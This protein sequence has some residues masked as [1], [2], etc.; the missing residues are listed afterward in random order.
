[1]PGY[2]LLNFSL[3]SLKIFIMEILISEA[4]RVAAP[5]LHIIHIEALIKNGPSPEELV[6]AI[7]AEGEDI[8]GRYEISQINKRTAIAATRKAYKALGK[9]PNRYRPSAEALARRMVQGKG[10][11]TLNRAVDTINLIS[12]HTGHSIGGFDLDKIEGDVLTLGVGQ[13]GEEFEAIGRGPLNI[14]G[15]PIYRDALGGI[16]TPTSDC[17][18]TKLTDDTVRLLMIVNIY[19]QEEDVK[20]TEAYCLEMLRRYCFAETITIEHITA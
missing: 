12:L 4:I 19:G 5:D 14:A 13:A 6:N 15:L 18:R 20:A 17:E 10:L 3:I 8:K 1:M 2:V 11:Y 9:D 16:G 7:I